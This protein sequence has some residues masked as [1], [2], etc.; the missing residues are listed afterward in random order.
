MRILIVLAGLLAC[1]CGPASE[2]GVP[3]YTYEVVHAYPHDH[4]AFTEGLFYDHGF[5]YEGTGLDAGR[6]TLRKVKLDPGEVLQHEQ[7]PDAYFGEGIVRW[8][9]KLY[10]MTYKY[11]IGFVY[12]FD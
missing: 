8:K 12:D 3:E 9:V 2:A 1:S 10:Q 7:L 5:L 4:T 11:E 6:S